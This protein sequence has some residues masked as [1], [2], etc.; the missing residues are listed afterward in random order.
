MLRQEVAH[1]QRLHTAFV[2]QLGE[3][4]PGRSGTPIERSRP[5]NHVHVDVFQLQQ[6]QLSVEGCKC[7]VVPLLGVAQLG[8]DPQMTALAP[9][10]EAGFG[11]GRGD[12]ALVVVARG[13]VDMPVPAA[14][15]DLT[16][17]ATSSFSIRSSPNP[18]CGIT[19]PSLSLIPGTL[20]AAAATARSLVPSMVVSLSSHYIRFGAY[21]MAICRASYTS[22]PSYRMTGIRFAI[23]GIGAGRQTTPPA[24]HRSISRH[25]GHPVTSP[26]TTPPVP[27]STMPPAMASSTTS[28]LTATRPWR[29][30]HAGSAGHHAGR[31]AL[32]SCRHPT[33][34]AQSA[35]SA[36]PAPSAPSALPWPS[37]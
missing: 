9:L 3:R 11:E 24:L 18:I 33:R 28:P 5:M 10:V 35:R 26:S 29:T 15:A 37:R 14:N 25:S 22:M 8:R 30:G 23:G 32:P 1:A 7:H 36:Y 20:A 6:S 21:A 16:T 12:A 34:W 27:M 13:S 4:L 31:A 19:L 17:G 2:A